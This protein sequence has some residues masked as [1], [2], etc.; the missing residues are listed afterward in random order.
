VQPSEVGDQP[1]ANLEHRET[2]V[3]CSDPQVARERELEPRTHRMALNGRDRGLVHA[4]QDVVRALSRSD[5]GAESSPACARE[6]VEQ[7][8]VDARAEGLALAR[9]EHHA[10]AGIVR[11]AIGRIPQ[12]GEHLRVDGVAFVGPSER[13]RRQA[14][15]NAV[16]DGLE[17][18]HSTSGAGRL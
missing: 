18:G 16:L 11:R 14:V 17:I 3:L 4:R 12:F 1:E 6:L 15:V 13:D 9:D 2:H 5:E 10:D 8:D 7:Q